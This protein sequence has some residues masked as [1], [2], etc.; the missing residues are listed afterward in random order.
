[1]PKSCQIRSNFSADLAKVEFV[2]KSDYFFFT[3]SSSPIKEC[4]INIE[5]CDVTE[6]EILMG[7]KQATQRQNIDC[8]HSL[9][10]GGL[11]QFST[12]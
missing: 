4:S 6:A 1:M 10:T 5:T 11:S 8:M 3:L 9:Q 12:I 2:E 7:G